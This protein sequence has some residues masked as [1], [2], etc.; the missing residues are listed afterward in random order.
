MTT[1][2]SWAV[3]D[4][5]GRTV[6]SVRGELDLAGTPLLL[7]A[8]FKR[9]AEQPSALVLD[10]SGM[11]VA[12]GLAMSVFTAVAGQAERWP[13]I[14]VVLC[15][16]GDRAAGL[17]ERRRFGNL[18][19]QPDVATALRGIDGGEVVMSAVNDRLLPVAGAVRHARNMATEACST[20]D[21]PELI[22]PASLVVSELVS[23]AVE[24]AGT[25]MTVRLSRRAR[26]LH[27]AVRDGSPDEPH[28][29]PPEPLSARRG[30]G[31]M[32][33]DHLA[34]HWGSLPTTDGKVVWATLSI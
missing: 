22:G 29:N 23:N 26:Y 5:G 13:G 1:P 7:A 2:L 21:L 8:L 12:Q 6:V 10:L 34:V 9:L 32:L 4:H 33:V 17:L 27:I 28:L 15:A 20:W 24:H 11:T 16:P 31:L 14:P 30:R 3:A 18:R 25:M 19:V